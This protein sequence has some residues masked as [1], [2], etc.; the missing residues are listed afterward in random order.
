VA[1]DHNYFVS[2]LGVL[3]HNRCQEVAREADKAVRNKAVRNA[4]KNEVEAV[5]NG[6]SKYNWTREELKQ[7]LTNGK[8]TGYDGCHIVDVSVNPSLAGDPNNIIFLKKYESFPGEVCHFMVH[9]GNWKNPSNW[10][11]V[12]KVMPQFTDM[13][14]A[15]GGTIL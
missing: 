4:W 8:V 5:K 12:V 9:N 2:S 11:P 10:A 13:I 14:L 1:D 6:T 15:V 7:L 3:V